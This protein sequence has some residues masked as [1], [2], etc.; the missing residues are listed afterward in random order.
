MNAV[1]LQETVPLVERRHHARQRVCSIVLVKLDNDNGGILLNLGTGGLSF[2][3]VARLNRGPKLV[4]HFKL[5]DSGETLHFEGS[6]AWVGPTRKEAGICFQ[7]VPESAQR[8]I[9]EWIA[10]QGAPTEAADLK[11]TSPANPAPVER[12][13]RP[14]P[15]AFTNEIDTPPV[16][17]EESE[18]N[19]PAALPSEPASTDALPASDL[20]NPSLPIDFVTSVLA[21]APTLPIHSGE[22]WPVS[23]ASRT[24]PSPK[25]QQKTDQ[26]KPPAASRVLTEPPPRVETLPALLDLLASAEGVSVDEWVPPLPASPLE[27][28]RRRKRLFVAELASSLAILALAL[29]SADHYQYLNISPPTAVATDV[30]AAANKP[31][32]QQQTIPLPTVQP[33]YVGTDLSIP[34]RPRVVRPRAEIRWDAK[35]RRFLGVDD[36]SGA[37]SELVDVLVWTDGRSG[38]YFCADSPYFANLQPG[39]VMTQSDALQSGYQP[40]LGGYCH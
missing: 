11:G 28:N 4:L 18:Q 5:P 25:P 1:P 38:Y 31:Q 34:P 35:F 39:S 30:P 21:Q 29:I 20:I 16:I 2:Q 12:W 27:R 32:A 13:A 8:L 7:D 26:P 40:K 37:D 36:S 6:V 17:F 19:P 33:G 9:S 14:A 10:K 24:Q 15:P 23:T 22:V 3:A